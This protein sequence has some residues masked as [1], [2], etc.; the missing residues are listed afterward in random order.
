MDPF[1]GDYRERMK[2]PTYL[3]HL[4]KIVLRRPGA[5]EVLANVRDWFQ[6]RAAK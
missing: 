1:F 2:N 4:E 5:Q 3:G 6:A